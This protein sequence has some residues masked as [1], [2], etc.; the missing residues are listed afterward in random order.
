MSCS[1]HRKTFPSWTPVTGILPAAAASWAGLFEDLE[2]G[3]DAFAGG[4]FVKILLAGLHGG[5]VALLDEEESGFAGGDEGVVGGIGHGHGA[6]EGREGGGFGGSGHGAHA[7]Q[8]KD[9]DGLALAGGPL[10]D[11]APEAGHLEGHEGGIGFGA[12]AVGDVHAAGLEGEGGGFQLLPQG[13]ETGFAGLLVADLGAGMLDD[14]NG[15]ALGEVGTKAGCEHLGDRL[16]EQGG[17]V[18]VPEAVGLGG[19]GGGEE[20]AG[21]GRQAGDFHGAG[22]RGGEWGNRMTGNQ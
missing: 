1:G 22:V 9:G 7:L 11:G 19:A 21:K 5:G 13:G 12:L 14:Q 6:V 8:E 16:V 20:Q 4:L 10:A 17:A 3:G 2:E 15:A 18:T